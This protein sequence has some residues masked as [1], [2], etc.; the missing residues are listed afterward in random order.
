MHPGLVG[1]I[2]LYAHAG[3]DDDPD[4]QHFQHGVV[5]LE[6]HLRHLAAGCRSAGCGASEVTGWA[7]DLSAKSGA[8]GACRLIAD[9]GR[10]GLQGGASRWS[11]ALAKAMRQS[12]RY[13]IGGTPTFW[14][15]RSLKAE[16]DR[17]AALASSST[18]HA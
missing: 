6:R 4:L 5:A 1:E 13:C 10:N 7:A 9:R 3:K 14:L 8:E 12:I 15:K 16:R 18:D 17:P 11:M 2:V